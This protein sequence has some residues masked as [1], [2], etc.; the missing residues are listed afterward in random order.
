MTDIAVDFSSFTDIPSPDQ[1]ECW[2]N[3]GVTRAIIGTRG[4]RRNFA[5]QAQ[6]CKDGG[7]EVEAYIYLYW[8]EPGTTQ[9]RNALDIINGMASRIWVDVEFDDNNPWPGSLGVQNVLYACFSELPADTGLYTSRSMWAQAQVQGYGDRALWDANYGSPPRPWVPYGDW[10]SRELVQYAGSVSLCG[11][12]V[13]LN[14]IEQEARMYDDQTIDVKFL[15]AI[16][17]L[18]GQM[19]DDRN[20]LA[21]AIGKLAQANATSFKGIEDRLTALE[22]K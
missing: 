13:D 22:A 15:K 1:V 20:E 6:A 10:T 5:A 18:Q 16:A 17:F 21:D 9:A 2:R 4:N 14:I 19:K 3:Q 11:L 8:N 12:N 7:L